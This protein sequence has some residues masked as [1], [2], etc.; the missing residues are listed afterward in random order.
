MRERERDI[1]IWFLRYH[2]HVFVTVY[3]QQYELGQVRWGQVSTSCYLNPCL[4]YTMH[5][6]RFHM[7]LVHDQQNPLNTANYILHAP[8]PRREK[9]ICGCLDY[10]NPSGLS[11]R[12]GRVCKTDSDAGAEDV[13][14]GKCLEQLGVQAG[15]SR[16]Q[17]QGVSK[18]SGSLPILKIIKFHFEIFL[19]TSKYD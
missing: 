15:D 6:L 9:R 17:K 2:H 3:S 12:T 14:M 18:K 1:K 16:Y 8:P 11:D 13:E 10:N 19:S 5:T 7:I 4:L